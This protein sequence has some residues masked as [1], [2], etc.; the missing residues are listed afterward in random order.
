MTA[1]AVTDAELAA[2]F[3]DV[4][5]DGDLRDHYAGRLER[6]LLLTRCTDCGRWTVPGAPVCPDCWSFEVRATEV[7]GLGTIHLLTLLHQG[8]SPDVIDYSGPHPVAVVE[9]VEQVGLRLTTTVV[10]VPPRAVTIGMPVELTWI[11]RRERPVP[12][13]RPRVAR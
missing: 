6:R 3:P 13:F 12:A 2:C 9:L 5:L 8:P 10:D 7:S 1:R 4:A 11:E